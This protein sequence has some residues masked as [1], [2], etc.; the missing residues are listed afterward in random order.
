M[1]AARW[2]AACSERQED[3]GA[4]TLGLFSLDLQSKIAHGGTLSHFLSHLP[5]ATVV[6]TDGYSQQLCL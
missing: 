2:L 1:K 3:K 4:I 5:Y 6:L